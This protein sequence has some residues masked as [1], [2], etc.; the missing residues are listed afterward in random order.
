MAID[1]YSCEFHPKST[2]DSKS[3]DKDEYYVCMKWATE[4]ERR[5]SLV[6]DL[7]AAL[8]EAERLASRLIGRFPAACEGRHFPTAEGP[9]TCDFCLVDD[10]LRIARAAIARAEKKE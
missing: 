9:G 3:C 8:T 1:L 4:V 5:A 2:R 10:I 7:L 6:P